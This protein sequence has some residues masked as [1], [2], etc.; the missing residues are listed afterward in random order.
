[1]GCVPPQGLFSMRKARRGVARARS[2]GNIVW[3]PQQVDIEGV[4]W[5]D[6]KWQRVNVQQKESTGGL[7]QNQVSLS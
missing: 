7:S 1:M 3:I 5:V 6:R 2:G 4:L